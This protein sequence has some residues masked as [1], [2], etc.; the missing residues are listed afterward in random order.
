M[1]GLLH[2]LRYSLRS[3]RN[4]PGF[5]L[6]AI[7]IIAIGIGATSTIFSWVR[8]V[9]LNPL[10]GA[11]QPQNVVALESI[12]PNGDWYATSYLDFRD[13][14]D[15]SKLIQSMS[16]TKPMALPVGNDQSVERVWGEAVSGNFF[17]LLGVRPEIGRFFSSAEVD[18]EQNAHPLLIISHSYW[19]SHYNADPHVIGSTIR[20]GHFPHTVIGVTPLGF[21]GSMPGLNFE[22]WA[23]ATM[24]GELSATGDHTLRDRKWRTFRVL[25]RL[26][27]GV[28][29]EQARAEVQS[30]ARLMAQRDADT[31]A[32]MSA[33]LQPLWKSH[34]GVQDSL[35]SPLGILMAACIVVLLIGC[36]NVENMLLVRATGRQKEFSIRLALG[37]PRIR[38]I[39]LV[40]AESLLIAAA[41]SLAG[42]V[43]AMW[44][45]GSL[46]Y[47]IPRS[48][49]PA[50][51][52]V[53]IDAQ[54]FLFAAALAFLVS[55]LVGI[56]PAFQGA[57]GNMN[58]MLKEGG[59][60]ISSSRSSRLLRGLFVTAEMA[61]AVIGIIGAGL[62]LM[63][64]HYVSEI[65][66][67]FD[68]NHV[69]LAQLDLSA[70]NYDAS[71]AASFYQRYTAQLERQPGIS[72]VAYSDYAPLSVSAGSWED[73]QVQGYVPTPGENMKIY[74][75]LIS[76]G[77]F[78]LLK[79]ALLQGRDFNALDSASAPPV[80][81]VN[82]E[83]V[84]RFIPGGIAVGRKVQ[85]WGK[86]FTIVGV[87]QD[88]KI[89][90]LTE[91]RTPYFYV[92]IAQIYRPEMGLVFFVRASGSL[93]NAITDL[94]REARAADPTIP[95]FDAS[96]LDDFIS[97]SL[98]PQR[99]AS[100]LLTVLAA[101]SLLLAAVGLYAVMAHSVAQRTNEIGIRM[102]L[103]AQPGHVAR[104]VVRQGM[105]YVL[106]GL[107]LGAI[108]AALL[109]HTASSSLVG[110]SPVDPLIYFSAALITILIAL[111]SIAV[112]AW[113]AV[114]VDPLTALRH[115]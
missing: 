84:R 6:I 2:D 35:R 76:P 55:P 61:L 108:D 24:Y 36:A 13:L 15:H 16:V 85:G 60:S 112:P 18:G 102:A 62:F 67:G 9:L 10:P 5:A 59:R 4:T 26:A 12:G 22:M 52:E 50:L 101:V 30:I 75:S 96:S 23:P 114:R 103:G 11:A 115:E 81:I 37:A 41:G 91:A 46:G 82:Q 63:S 40:L 8:A 80:M 58:E 88:T 38:L 57:K 32:G 106:A 107:A 66:P 49:S 64:F 109:A 44:L 25:A 71:Q 43:I 3:L 87:V 78:D 70:G 68:S 94:R 90:R 21:H 111:V 97:E 51:V 100:S 34:Y 93:D 20:I 19:T 79:I 33:T 92:P 77:Y 86:W 7:A 95:V 99:I 45:S 105:V 113:R 47:L 98:F 39:R 110:I 54:V 65:H 27:P 1:S 69:A 17:D 74:R 104:L 28:S 53:P 56:V 89:Y 72:A 31:N 83:F 14:R 29:I 42:L 48:S 73:L